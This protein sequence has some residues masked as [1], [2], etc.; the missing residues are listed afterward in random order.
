MAPIIA[1]NNPLLN[2]NAP[3]SGNALL[4]AA[5]GLAKAQVQP[6]INQLLGEIAQ[7]NTQSQNALNATGGYFSQLGQ[8]AQ[9]GLTAAQGIQSGLNTQLQGLTGQ[10]DQQLQGIGSNA[11]SDLAKYTG[12]V[13]AGVGAGGLA[14]EIA[15]QQ[16]L[17]AQNE[18]SIR[19]LGAAQG[20]NASSL[21]ASNLGTFGLKGQE[22][23]SNIAQAGEVKN[24]P[25]TSKL[26]T[27]NATY[28]AD[29]AT[30]L[31]KLRQQEITNQISDAGLG[32]KQQ[33]ANAATQNANTNTYKAQTS[34][35]QGEQK[36]GQAQQKIGQG[37]QKLN[38]TAANQS[39]QNNPAAVGSK[40]WTNVQNAGGKQW[41][42]NPNA[43]GSPAWARV[44]TANA[45]AGNGTAK[46]LS[47]LENNHF[48]GTIGQIEQ[49]I[50]NGQAAGQQG[51]IAGYLQSGQNPSKKAFD[52][53]M[54]NVAEQLLGYGAINQSTAA[55]L[56]NQYG[57]RGGTYNNAPIK[58]TPNYQPP[59]LLNIGTSGGLPSVTVGAF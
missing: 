1:P 3:L 24:E 43:V 36:I 19:A 49:L 56:H 21:A 11:M 53:F 57:V 39:F 2:P 8:Q 18:G 37:Q 9:Q 16:G 13:G 12:G 27:E 58:V 54:I 32:I 35:T 40:A 30:A 44:Q 52:P 38:Q 50:K 28:G 14:S 26:A 48:W 45:R 42:D 7:N 5:Q 17:A 23:L 33:T 59:P 55:T 20:A 47:T 41:S 6:A 29:L 34:A 31:G 25:L 10:E 46:P 22:A 4:Q 15:R 51:K